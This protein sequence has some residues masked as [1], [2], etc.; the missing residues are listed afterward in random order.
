MSYSPWGLRESD[1]T[2]QQAGHSC[3]RTDF[4]LEL[5]VNSDVPCPC[6]VSRDR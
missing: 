4:L 5:G 2:E 6:C 1:T 3:L